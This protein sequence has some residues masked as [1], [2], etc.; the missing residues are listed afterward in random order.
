[1][2]FTPSAP[3]LQAAYS[4]LKRRVLELPIFFVGTAGSVGTR[5]VKGREFLYRQYYDAMG[6]KVAD[7][8]GPATDPAAL[9]RADELRERIARTNALA[10]DARFLAREGYVR[11]DGRTA[12]VVAAL[13]NRGLFRA[14][15]V[16]VGSHAYGALLNELGVRAAAFH[17][18]DLD[19]ARGKPLRDPPK[20][21]FATILEESRVPLS[22]IA[23]FDR[24]RTVT[25]WKAPGRDP[26]RVDLLVPTAGRE[27]TVAAVPELAAHAMALPA[28]A[29]L[30]DA[31][32]DAALL[33]REGAIAVKVPRPE[34]FAWHKMLV[35]QSRTTTSDKKD[36]DLTQ[37]TVLVAALAEREPGALADAFAAV[38]P[39]HR[40]KLRRGAALVQTK[41]EHAKASRAA[42]LLAELTG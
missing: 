5:S 28:L 4:D 24:K 18:Q 15:A 26:F 20:E 34:A 23:G 1:M 42:E 2:L 12:A 41:L 17:T 36:K 8:I 30:L 32:I 6:A 38:P 13:A 31:P 21:S 35:A 29:Y 9:A 11:A 14:G 7:Y 33:A 27:I 40:T 3:A 25:S 22:P 10:A 16:L 37:A 19:V 39:A